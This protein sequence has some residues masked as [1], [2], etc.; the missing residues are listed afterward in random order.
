M[1]SPMGIAVDRSGNIWVSNTSCGSTGDTSCI[2]TLSEVFATGF[3][4]F[5]PLSLQAARLQGTLPP[6]GST[7]GTGTPHPMLRGRPV[8]RASILQK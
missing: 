3:P 4:T 2:F 7:E 5:T 6:E 8:A 1:V